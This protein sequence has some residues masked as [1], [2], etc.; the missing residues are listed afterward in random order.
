MNYSTAG[1]PEIRTVT[2]E[3]ATGW[4]AESWRLFK[5]APAIWIA[6]LLIYL[7]IAVL[8]G[9]V[10]VIGSLAFSLLTPVFTFGWLQGIRQL[11]AGETLKIEHLF[12]GFQSPRLSQLI[13]LGL[14]SMAIGLILG[15]IAG[16]GM[17]GM[18]VGAGVADSGT[19]M[20]VAT[21]FVMLIGL[22][23]VAVLIAAFL[24]ATPLVGFDDVAPTAAVQLSIRASLQNWLP[25]TVWS[26]IMLL[27]TLLGSI[28]FGLG[29]LVV[30]P[31]TIASYY[32]AYRD[33]LGSN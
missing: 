25:L 27:L 17:A 31:M 24:F 13:L 14:L 3:H 23:V 4:V 7:V 26:L 32:N 9:L 19:A 10:P 8:S 1:V 29:L 30:I 12:A 33:I 20:G 6:I 18:F 28:P 21:L 2:V 11:Q 5:L 16:L 15:F 22:A